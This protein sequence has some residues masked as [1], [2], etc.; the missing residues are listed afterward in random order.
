VVAGVTVARYL[1]GVVSL[2]LVWS[3][4]AVAA[5]ALR[6]RLLSHWTG[7]PARLAEA[8]LG[9]AL[10]I[11]MLELLGTLG[12]FRLGP[13][14]AASVLVGL[15]GVRLAPPRVSQPSGL[16]GGVATSIALSASAALIASWAGPTLSSYEFGIRGFDSLWYHL[17]WAAS[18]AQTGH[19]TGLRFTDVEYLTAFYPAS[20]ELVHGLG[21]VLLGRDTLSP[22]INLIWLG[23]LLLAAYCV[24]R[25]RGLGHATLLGAAIVM[26]TPALT[27]SQGGSAANDVAGVFFLLAAVALILNADERPAALAL[28][29]VAA[30]LAIATKLSLLGPV[31]ALTLGALAITPPGRRRVAA[32]RWLAPLILIGGFWYL[33]N[34]IAVGNPLPWVDIPGLA[35]PAPALQQHTAFSVAH[36]AT[37]TH[38]WTSI[39]GPG[40]RSGFGNWWPALLLAALIGPLL[41]LGRGAGRSVRILGLVA[42]ASL[43]AYL[44]TPE[45]AAG[46][47]GDPTGFAFNLRYAAPGLTLCLTLLPLAPVLSGSERARQATVAVLALLL[48]ATLASGQ[49]W[50]SRQLLGAIAVGVAVLAAGAVVARRGPPVGRI[51]GAAVLLALV[52][53]GAAGGYAWQRRYLH[54]RYAFQPGV[55][56]LSHVWARFRDIH[57]ARVGIVG[58]FGGFFSYP[59]FGLD[60]SN[61]V[62]YVGLRGPHGSFTAITSCPRWRAAVN[63]GRLQYVVTTPARDPWQPKRLT[64]S[65]ESAWTASDPAAHLLYSRRANGQRVAVYELSGQLNP[66]GCG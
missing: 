21:I 23:L 17:P 42:L 22:A 63:A 37:D 14:V 27:L 47:A 54:G 19:I 64:L 18:F 34:L 56:F 33:R 28:G 57:H 66:G 65:P 32:S 60:D 8:V 26:A 2:V 20:A 24:G 55:S 48:V 40:L 16:R 44:L 31:L 45:S 46:P 62:Q 5:V 41:C 59:L 10:L 30:G 15:G 12:L 52:L 38:I 39:F 11:V 7:P 3:S 13:I 50:P 43:L 1:L 25:P 61:R 51:A 53:A 49:L 29:G 9:L 35:T 58:T 36:Y 6:R 4:I